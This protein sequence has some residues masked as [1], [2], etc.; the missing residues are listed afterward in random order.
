MIFV[1]NADITI[2]QSYYL[3]F[4]SFKFRHLCKKQQLIQ[5]FVIQGHIPLSS[6]QEHWAGNSEKMSIFIAAVLLFSVCVFVACTCRA[7][8]HVS[9]FF[10]FITGVLQYISVLYTF[11]HTYIVIFLPRHQARITCIGTL[12]IFSLEWKINVCFCLHHL[13]TSSQ[14]SLLSFAISFHCSSCVASISRNTFTRNMLH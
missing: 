8:S 1:G 7:L 11:P 12:T 6:Q 14:H 9:D 10:N 4:S 2:P 13:R 3:C 5:N